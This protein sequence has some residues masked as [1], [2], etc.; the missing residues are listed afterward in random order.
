MNLLHLVAFAAGISAADLSGLTIIGDPSNPGHLNQSEVN[1]IR[2]A[3]QNPDATR[4]VGFNLTGDVK[5]TWRVNVTNFAA[6][7]GIDADQGVTDPHYITTTH[8]LSWDGKYNFS[9]A[10]GGDRNN[11]CFYVVDPIDYPVNI[12]DTYTDDQADS[13]DCT[14]VLGEACVSA[15]LS[16]AKNAIVPKQCSSVGF[17]SEFP[18]C[19][20]TLGYARQVTGVFATSGSGWDLS[21]TTSQMHENGKGFFGYWSDQQSGTNE[22]KYL[23][24]TNQLQMVLLYG[25]LPTGKVAELLCTRVNSTKLAESSDLNNDGVTLTSEA[26]FAQGSSSST[27]SSTSSSPS[28]SHSTPSSGSS[29]RVSAALAAACL[30]V[31]TFISL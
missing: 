19:A 26:L 1:Q 16:R 14:P 30:A 2:K 10:L 13:S 29:V 20:G 18:E 4:S 9:E 11:F 8:D 5:W 28:A 15:I 3:Q 17:W 12:T 6:P 7:D 25:Q 24:Q 31:F 23:Q 27:P 22:T 21:N